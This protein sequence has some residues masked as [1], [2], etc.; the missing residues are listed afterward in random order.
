M[1]F[2]RIVKHWT[3]SRSIR[4]TDIDILNSCVMTMRHFEAFT[5]AWKTPFKFNI[6]R[7]GVYTTWYWHRLIQRSTNYS[8]RWFGAHR[9]IYKYG[10][11][12]K[13]NTSIFLLLFILNQA[14]KFS[15]LKIITPHCSLLF[16]WNYLIFFLDSVSSKTSLLL[17]SNQTILGKPI[18]T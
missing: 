9:G 5:T 14:K 3:T 2:L 1:C 16:W 7:I 15:Q 12:K 13:R 17:K 6:G 4:S 8:N 18:W 11:K 10:E